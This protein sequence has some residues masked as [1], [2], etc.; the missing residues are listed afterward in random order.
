M[1]LLVWE[2][3]VMSV[4]VAALTLPSECG[5]YLRTWGMTPSILMVTN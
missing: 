2:E 3:T 1:L 4:I 5:G